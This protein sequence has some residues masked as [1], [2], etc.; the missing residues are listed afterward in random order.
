M[1]YSVVDMLI[2]K[3]TLC[4]HKFPYKTK[5]KVSLQNKVQSLLTKQSTKFAYKTKHKVSSQNKV[6]SFLTKQSTKFPYK[7]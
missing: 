2:K 6:Q 5:Y 3:L 7:A 1:L 4:L